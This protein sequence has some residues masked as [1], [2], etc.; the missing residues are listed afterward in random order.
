[1][2]I[3]KRHRHYSF[4][5]RCA[6]QSKQGKLTPEKVREAVARLDDYAAKLAALTEETNRWLTAD[7][8]P[9]QGATENHEHRCQQVQR[10]FKALIAIPEVNDALL[11]R[12]ARANR[13]AS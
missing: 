1:M 12:E 6:F 4:E 3:N 7:S 2:R 5:E 13:G 10:K 11:K 8:P 9:S